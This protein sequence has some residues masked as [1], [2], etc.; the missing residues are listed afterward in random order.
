MLHQMKD[1]PG[2]FEQD[3]LRIIQIHGP[4]DGLVGELQHPEAPLLPIEFFRII[5]QQ[6]FLLIPLAE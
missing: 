5:D 2:V 6:F 4:L 3:P 1:R